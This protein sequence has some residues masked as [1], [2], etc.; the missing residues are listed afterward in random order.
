MTRRFSNLDA[1][2]VRANLERVHERI[3]GAGREPGSVEVCAAVKY[4]DAAELPALAEAGIRLV[5]ENRAQDLLAKQRRASRP[6]RVG[7]HRR[8]AEPQGA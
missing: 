5:G 6:A 2:A 1:G 8:A 7:L 4:V 3:A